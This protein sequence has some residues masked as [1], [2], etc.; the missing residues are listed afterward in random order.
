VA[1]LT[2][3]SGM[4]SLRVVLA[5]DDGV[6]L[7]VLHK[8][9]VGMGHQVIGE[10][11]DG[12][13]AVELVRSVQPDLVFLDIRMPEVDGLEAARQIQAIRPTPVII[14]SA[15][16]ESGLGSQAAAAGAHAYLVKPFTAAQ[17][18]PAIELALAN[19][20]KSAQ[21]EQKL[22]QMNEA[23]ETRKLVERAKGILMRDVGIDEEAAYLRLQKTA[24]NEN[25]KLADVARAVIMADQLKRD[26]TRNPR[27]AG[28]STR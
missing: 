4:K 26:G 12:R 8:I 15:H 9:L 22:Q 5:D 1:S 23:L 28:P 14:V 7:M 3:Q 25:R 10:S 16:T 21:L 11:A 18:K 24:R 6:T 2:E 13:Q 20:E 19:F 17:I 27:G